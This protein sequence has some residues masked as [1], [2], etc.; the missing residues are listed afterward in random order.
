MPSVGRIKQLSVAALA[1]AF[2]GITASS[3]SA[4]P[5][6][7][8]ACHDPNGNP[9][10]QTVPDGADGTCAAAD[11]ALNNYADGIRSSVPSTSDSRWYLNVDPHLRL[12]E[13]RINRQVSA[14]APGQT[15]EVKT[16]LDSPLETQ[17]ADDQPLSG[18]ATFTAT[19][20]ADKP[21]LGDWVRFGV[22][23]ASPGCTEAASASASAVGMRVE[24]EADPAFAVGRTRSPITGKLPIHIEAT[25]NGSGL[26]YAT[27][28]LGTLSVSDTFKGGGADCRDLTDGDDRVD[29]PIGAD[30]ALTGKLDLEIDTVG[31]TDG[32]YTLTVTVFDWA[33][34][35]HRMEQPIKVLNILPV[36]SSSQTL[37]IGT[38]GIA[39]PPA[40]NNNGGSGGV[41]GASS[42]QCRSPRLSV[43]LAQKPL[44]V[45]RGV[46]VLK[47]GKRYRFK[48]RLTCVINGRRRSA[49]KRTRI[50]ILNTVG[51]RT[52]EKPGTTIGNKGNL[53]VILSYRSSRLIT[54]RFTNSDR[55]RSQVRI[56]I[57]V[58][59][60]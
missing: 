33:G 42:Q 25:D 20:P 11:P 36:H 54:F 18:S 14:L 27:A 2:M 6:W 43:F 35:S 16:S 19:Q 37:S 59:K 7:L 44:R 32:D 21:T 48:G 31:L 51:R 30:C 24:D 29:M 57:R 39:T 34:R 15:Y 22:S 9:L 10:P 12:V 55:Q 49:P 52:V 3:A 47:S 5:V 53:T 38:S 13:L 28:Q 58:A 1:A 45:R 40:S 23:C 41:A 56:R 4:A 26:R 46:P 8:W 50:D 60:R 17:D